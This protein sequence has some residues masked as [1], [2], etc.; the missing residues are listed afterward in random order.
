MYVLR[1]V[2]YCSLQHYS[3]GLFGITNYSSMFHWAAFLTNLC[4]NF[5]A[6]LQEKLFKKLPSAVKPYNFNN[7]S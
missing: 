5:V 7:A 6:P 3:S 4:C 2:R 1:K